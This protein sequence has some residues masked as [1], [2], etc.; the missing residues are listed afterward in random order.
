MA[1]T[2]Y[3]KMERI[4]AQILSQNGAII[5]MTRDGVSGAEQHLLHAHNI[6]EIHDML[7]RFFINNKELIP[8]ALLALSLA[9]EGE[10]V[11]EDD[12]DDDDIENLCMN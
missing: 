5:A 7:L 4:G 6:E 9:I 11:E 3:E 10:L 2:I 8:T 1:K 12:A